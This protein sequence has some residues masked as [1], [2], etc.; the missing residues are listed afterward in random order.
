MNYRTPSA[1]SAPA[2][3]TAISGMK[4]C[5]GRWYD[6]SG[7]HALASIYL[8]LYNDHDYPA[9]RLLSAACDNEVLPYL[10]AALQARNDG[11]EPQEWGGE[12]GPLIMEIIEVY[13]QQYRRRGGAK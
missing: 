10:F 5:V 13:G 2:T 3:E 1:T 12:S 9:P 8:H 11:H 4:L 6:T 7:G